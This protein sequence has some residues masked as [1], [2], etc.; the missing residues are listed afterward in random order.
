MKFRARFFVGKEAARGRRPARERRG[1]ESRAAAWEWVIAETPMFGVVWDDGAGGFTS[2]PPV[3]AV[4][5]E[6]LGLRVA[7]QRTARRWRLAA[8]WRRAAFGVWVW[9][10]RLRIAGLVRRKG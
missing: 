4:V 5:E 9:N 10:A 2:A 3:R 7:A 1:F 6:Q 8:H